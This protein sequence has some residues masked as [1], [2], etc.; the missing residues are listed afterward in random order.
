MH[1]ENSVVTVC[2]N[3]LDTLKMCVESVASQADEATEHIVVDGASTDGTAGWLAS[4][5]LPHLRFVSEP[6]SGIYNAMNKGWRMARGTWIS[7]LNADDVYLPHTLQ[8][9]RAAASDEVDVI[10]GNLRKERLL[11]GHW[12][13]RIEK[14]DHQKMLQTMG[15]FHPATFWRRNLADTVGMYDERYRFSA[16]YDL[17]LRMFLANCRFRHVDEVLAIFRV[18]G[19]STLDCTSYQEG[20]DIM[21]RHQTGYA[22]E[23]VKEWQ[24]CKRKVSKLR[25]ILTLARLTGTMPLIEKR[26]QRNWIPNHGDFGA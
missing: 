4:L 20:V 14:P 7:F 10:Y 24:L 13:H 22:D 1:I 17:V 6:D 8:K 15:V 21:R 25:A 23:L 2:F 11:N 16:D 9:V 12:F 3:A 18:G 19:A 26:M 5:N